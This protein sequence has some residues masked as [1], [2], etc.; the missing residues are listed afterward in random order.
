[1]EWLND[2]LCSKDAVVAY[3]ITIIAR[4]LGRLGNTMKILIGTAGLWAENQNQGYLD[5]KQECQPLNSNVR[6]YRKVKPGALGDRYCWC[7]RKTRDKS[8][9][10]MMVVVVIVVRS[11]GSSS[12]STM[13]HFS[14]RIL[15]SLRQSTFPALCATWTF[16]HET[17]VGITTNRKLTFLSATASIGLNACSLVQDNERKACIAMAWCDIVY[18]IIC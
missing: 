3:R 2:E 9:V 17:Q 6:L 11:N 13:E 14:L 4:W 1:M 16:T 18:K 5:S 10:M 8:R 12:S 15:H 7:K